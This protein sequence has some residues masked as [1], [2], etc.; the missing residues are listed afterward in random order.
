MKLVKSA[1][2]LTFS[3]FLLASTGRAQNTPVVSRYSY[4][5]GT[6]GSIPIT[7]HLHQYGKDV[8]GYYYYNKQQQ[9]IA[10]QGTAEKDSLHLNAY[11]GSNSIDESFE[12]IWK[13]DQ[14]SGKWTNNQNNKSLPFNW[15]T[16]AAKSGQF[17]YVFTEGSKSMANG[18]PDG[19]SGEYV[20][21]TIW[22]TDPGSKLIPVVRKLA[23]IA[24]NATPGATFLKRK[25]AFLAD[26]AKELAG[27]PPK[28]L[29]E[30]G[31]GYN[32]SSETHLALAYLTDQLAVLASSTYEFSGGAHGNYGTTFTTIDLKTGKVLTLADILTPAGK[33]K[34][35]ALLAAAFRKQ[36]GVK[37]TES[38]QD[39]GLFEKK[40]ELTNNCYLTAT[41]LTF[42]YNPYEIGPYAL[43]QIVISIPLSQLEGN[44]LR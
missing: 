2:V 5:T 19:P 41:S 23:K 7:M 9:P 35:P 4:L 6:I 33:Q 20:E 1:V 37:P 15:Q 12:G 44:L 24:G 28:E 26:Y 3:A 10:C 27:V 18:K 39:A 34:I 38:L 29:A 31:E 8:I 36:Y 43:G 40:I 32:R 13:S 11:L 30:S 25:N 16:D 14:V 17:T 21:G 22:P 42:C